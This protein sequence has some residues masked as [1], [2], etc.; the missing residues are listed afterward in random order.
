MLQNVSPKPRWNTDMG[1]TENRS[2]SACLSSTVWLQKNH[3]IAQNKWM[4]YIMSVLRLKGWQALSLITD[5][6][7]HMQPFLLRPCSVSHY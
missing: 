3:R 7:I 6:I 5:N 1:L 4:E 2:F